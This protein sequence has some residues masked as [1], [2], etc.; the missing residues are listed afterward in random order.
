M[1]GEKQDVGTER[2]VRTLT[3]DQIVTERKVP[4][5]LFLSAAS[6]VIVGGAAAVVSSLRAAR[7][8]GD[9]KDTDKRT[10]ADY[11]SCDSDRGDAKHCDKD[12]AH[13]KDPKDSDK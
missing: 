8:G 6:A 7:V 11:K 3:D 1:P 10:V 12:K 4:R 5:R 9:P 2:T 13:F